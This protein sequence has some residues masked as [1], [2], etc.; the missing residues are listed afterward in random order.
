MHFAYIAAHCFRNTIMKINYTELE[1][2]L[3]DA[4]YTVHKDFMERFAGNDSIV[5][6]GGAKLEAFITDLQNEFENAAFSFLR[7]HALE[8]DLEARR[9]ALAITKLHAKRCVEDFSKVDS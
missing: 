3:E 5:S 7:R 1:K 6:V 8:K 2:D 4:C 9:R